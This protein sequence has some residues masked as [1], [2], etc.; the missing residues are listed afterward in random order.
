[1]VDDPFAAKTV[2]LKK[3]PSTKAGEI[4]RGI[5]GVNTGKISK[6]KEKTPGSL[7]AA[8]K[9]STNRLAVMARSKSDLQEKSAPLRQSPFT[10]RRIHARELYE[11]LPEGDPNTRV[12]FRVRIY[13]PGRSS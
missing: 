2:A 3:N 1:M 10:F 9:T 7:H 11:P 12:K 8:R 4:N 13:Q 6:R 5:P